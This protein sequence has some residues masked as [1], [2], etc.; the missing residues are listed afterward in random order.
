MLATWSVIDA[1]V[2]V[3]LPIGL[4]FGLAWWISQKYS[5]REEG[6]PLGRI[7]RCISGWVQEVAR[8]HKHFN[9]KEPVWS[10][11]SGVYKCTWAKE[12]ISLGIDTKHQKL[13]INIRGEGLL[14]LFFADSEL[15]N[16]KF[17]NV[18]LRNEATKPYRKSAW[19]LLQEVRAKIGLPLEK[20]GSAITQYEQVL[21]GGGRPQP[22]K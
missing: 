18:D 12:F 5:G 15:M 17:G 20:R 22:K 21:K 14:Q 8:F 2:I 7:R 4:L 13:S 3:V 19:A 1:M 16:L 9:M 10:E 6:V 11:K